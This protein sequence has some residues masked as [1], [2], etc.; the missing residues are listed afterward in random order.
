MANNFK[1]DD[2]F[3]RKLVI[4]AAG[5]EKTLNEMKKMGFVPIELERGSTGYKIWKEIKIKRIRVPDILCLKTGLRV[6]SRG[7]TSAEISMSHSLKKSERAWD[8]GMRNNDY[9]S[10]IVF[11]QN[12]DSAIDVRVCSPVHFIKVEDLRKVYG[13]K[14]V[15][16]STPKGVEEGSEIRVIWTS[17]SAKEVSFV[18]EVNSDTIILRSKSENKPQRIKLHRNKKGNPYQLLPQ[19][20]AGELV[21]ANQIVASV[22]PVYKELSITASQYDFLSDLK[23]C[24]L[25]E[26]YAAAKA[27]RFLGYSGKGKK[28]LIDRVNNANE[29]IYVR[30]EAAAAL[31][32]FEHCEGWDFL[33]KKL[34]PSHPCEPLDTQLETIIV[35]SELR[36]SRSQTALIKVL[37]DT[38]RNE[39]L[40]AGAA[41]GLGQFSS[42]KSAT[43][44]V[45]TFNQCSLSV[46]VESARA[47]LNIACDQTPALLKMFKKAGGQEQAGI[48]WALAKVGHFNPQMILQ[49]DNQNLRM[50]LAYIL[51]YG[52]NNFSE[53]NLKSISQNDPE[54]YFAASVLW[55][56]LDSWINNL[57]EY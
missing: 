22:V 36:I 14:Q 33:E 43:A 30:L 3:L 12:P 37:K 20:Q 32:K 15:E 11:G 40:R 17:A 39:E 29:D 31:A 49:K 4:G 18:E 52:K 8:F 45:D 56:I 47:L 53:D 38:N 5:T 9:V 44:L 25:S 13:K 19:V 50:W 21:E 55:Q 26:R 16:I 2:S 24:L 7:K 27:L 48:S 57:R 35:L 42:V 51:G 34:N 6:E 46:K 10:I 54:V 1:N 23:S 41:W 28:L